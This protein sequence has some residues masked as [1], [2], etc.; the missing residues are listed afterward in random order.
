[1]KRAG[2]ADVPDGAADVFGAG[3]E[4][5]RRYATLLAGPGVERGLLGPREVDRLWER[6][7]LNCAVLGELVDPGERVVDIGS[8]AGLPGLALAI[9]RPDLRVSLVEPLLRRATFLREAVEDLDLAV[10][11]VRGRAEEPAVRAA[12]GGADVVTSR[13]VA[14]LDRLT[15][16]SLP[17]LRTGGRML[18]IKGER[19]AREV[20]EHRRGMAALGAED[21]RVVKCG[22]AFLAVPATVVSAVRGGSSRVRPRPAKRAGR[23]S[24]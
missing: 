3:L 13:A 24:R 21:V 2:S 14:P 1:M 9:A 5:A 17:L 16:W 19:A 7:L 18:A 10:A 4:T 8:G 12:V 23:R 6:H 11:V 22:E 20:A 15:T